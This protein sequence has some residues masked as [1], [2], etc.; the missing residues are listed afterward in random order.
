MKYYSQRRPWIEA[1]RRR[2]DWIT[3]PGEDTR[4]QLIQ[5]Y[6]D[7]DRERISVIPHGLLDFYL[8]WKRPED[9]EQPGTVLFFGR[10]NAYKGLGV[11]LEAWQ[12]VTRRCPHAKLIIAGRGYDLPKFRGRILQDPQCE[13]IDRFIPSE[14]VASLFAQSSL[15]V[16][17]YVEATQSGVLATALA[18]GKPV[19]VTSVGS[20]PEMV[21]HGVNGF[22]VPPKDVNALADALITLIED[23]LLRQRMGKA[24]VRLAQTR[25]GWEKLAE[26]TE[27]VYYQARN[28]HGNGGI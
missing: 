24:A 23:A 6:P 11:L 21:E 16:L 18:F 1:L 26:Q 25:L 2:A 5:A 28:A 14:E 19:V 12:K 15:I 3:V 9:T 22:I 10:I 8:R 13:L 20:L 27:S 7:L 4:R 17:P